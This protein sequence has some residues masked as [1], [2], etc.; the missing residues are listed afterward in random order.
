MAKPASPKLYVLSVKVG[1]FTKKLLLIYK[2]NYGHDDH[3]EV[4]SHMQETSY[5][6]SFPI[7]RVL[8]LEIII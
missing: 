3:N 7:D 6:N 4:L 5:Y 8:R 1:A 2:P